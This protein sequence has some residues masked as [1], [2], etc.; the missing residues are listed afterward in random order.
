MLAASHALAGA[1]IAAIAPNPVAGYLLALASHP[2]LDFFPHW[3]LN[4][5]FTPRSKFTIIAL[6]LA[7]AAIGIIPG[8]FLFV[9][10]VQPSVLIITMLLAQGPDW[11]EAPYHVFNWRFPPFSTIKRLQ[12]RWH[13]KLGLPWGLILQLVFVTLLVWI[14]R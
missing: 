3:D 8:Y 9:S 12:S 5:R 6:S 11:L 13:H 10:Q 14:T 7:D 2:L 1:A 4:T